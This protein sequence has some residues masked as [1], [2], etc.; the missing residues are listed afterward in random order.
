MIS[1]IISSIIQLLTDAGGAVTGFAVVVAL[2]VVI[3]G[4]CNADTVKLLGFELVVVPAES[5]CN[6]A[7]YIPGR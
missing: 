3:D 6:D 1:S 7:V 5:I 2:I 4:F